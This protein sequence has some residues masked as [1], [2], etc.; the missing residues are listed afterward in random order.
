VSI[1]CPIVSYTGTAS[2][3][4]VT[5]QTFDADGGV[6]QSCQGTLA[7]NVLTGTCTSASTCIF[8]AV[9]Q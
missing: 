9:K 1:A 4:S 8:S 5:F 6:A 3:D 2:G 7:G